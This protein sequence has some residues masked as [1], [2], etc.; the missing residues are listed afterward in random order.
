[1]LW[2]MV[3]KCYFFTLKMIAAPCSPTQLAITCSNLTTETLKQ[4]VK[5]S[6]LTIKIPERTYFT[7]CFSVSIV[8]F[9]QAN[10][11]WWLGT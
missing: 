9:E 4:G 8:N 7:H 2:N 11:G 3:P 10:A 6:K 1:M 5:C